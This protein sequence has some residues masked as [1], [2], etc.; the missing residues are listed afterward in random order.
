MRLGQA[1]A[2]RLS[3]ATAAL[4]PDVETRLR[5]AREQALSRAREAARSAAAPAPAPA[6]ALQGWRVGWWTAAATGSGAGTAAPRGLTAAGGDPG[7]RRP[8]WAQRLLAVFPLLLLLAG[9][10]WVHE[11]NQRE[12]VLAL[13]EL[14]AELLTD[15][16]HPVLYSD[17]GFTEFLRD[18]GP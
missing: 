10:Q 13:A 3:Q 1:V 18:P 5:F 4:N 17:P 2:Q 8:S 15:E 9:L 7:S 16:L 6:P 14:D 12:R 11:A